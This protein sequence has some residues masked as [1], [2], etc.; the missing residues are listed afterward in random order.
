MGPSTTGVSV[1]RY[2]T[3]ANSTKPR[4]HWDYDHHRVLYH[5]PDGYDAYRK[6]GRGKYSEVFA[7]MKQSTEEPVII[8]ILKPV[9][10]KKIRREILAMKHQIGMPYSS[11]L[12]D[13][14]KD[15]V[16][17]V[18]TLITRFNE[19]EDFKTLFPRLSPNHARIYMYQ[20]LWALDHAHSQGVMH[21]DVKP[22]NVVI[23]HDN[24][25][26]RLI[27]WGLAEFYHPNT[28]YNCRVASRY[29]KGP[30]LLLNMR[31]YD[32]STDMW[33]FGAT[34]AGL[35]YVVHPFFNGSDNL[36]MIDKQARVM[37]SEDFFQY[38]KKYKI[39]DPEGEYT[40]L[41]GNHKK[42]GL[43]LY[44]NNVNKHLAT[45]DAVDL[46]SK[47]LV[48]D[49]NER[50]SAKEAMAHPYFDPVR[51]YVVTQHDQL[52]EQLKEEMVYRD[53]VDKQYEQHGSEELS[54]V[55]Y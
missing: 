33:S 30:E 23:D 35:I 36:D 17:R 43:D 47:L 41:I 42:K 15:P 55:V 5:T 52:A 22:Q 39:E 46:L 27:D 18:T 10:K 9:K 44:I 32:Y 12:I 19:D 50:L 49:H 1:S 3:N 11:Q 53:Q 20:L 31:D 4:E 14:L 16:N 8:K 13:V 54:D 40:R 45:D 24:Q 2:Y 28:E 6:I 21:R 34:F 25:V 26:L 7:G 51:S 29:F 38:M 48:V 37:G